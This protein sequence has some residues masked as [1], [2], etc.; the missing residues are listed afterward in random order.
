MGS[1]V[2]ARLA[3]QVP[4]FTLL[5]ISCVP[6]EAASWF[7][8]AL[9]RNFATGAVARAG[10]RERPLAGDAISGM[11]A[12]FRSPYLAGIA[13]FILLMTFA[14]TILYFAQ[15]DL[16]YE[17]IT[18]RGERRAFLARIDQVVNFLTIVFEVWLTARL[19]RWLGVGL[20]LAAVPI[21]VTVGFVFLGLYPTLWTLVIVQVLYRAGRSGS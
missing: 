15:S 5:L 6:L 14:S 10:E 3:V 19:I 2:T 20:A 12:V 11:K 7:A 1:E 18:D 13:A 17:A 16:V 8:G 9:H 4:V 21:A